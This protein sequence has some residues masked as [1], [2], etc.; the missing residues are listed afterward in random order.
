MLVLPGLFFGDATKA[1]IFPRNGSEEVSIILSLL[2][3]NGMFNLCDSDEGQDKDLEIAELVS[4]KKKKYNHVIT[5]LTFKNILRLDHFSH[6]T[7]EFQDLAYLRK[8]TKLS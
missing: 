7:L 3:Y 5:F 6:S 1:W 2:K 4:V 8:R